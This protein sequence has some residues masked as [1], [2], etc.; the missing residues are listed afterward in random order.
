MF[1]D[2]L[3]ID[4]SR[5]FSGVFK[6]EETRS[7]KATHFLLVPR[8]INLLQLAVDMV[9]TRLFTRITIVLTN[10]LFTGYIAKNGGVIGKGNYA[11]MLTLNN[12]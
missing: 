7:L 4:K 10:N 1:A 9:V 2:A 12:Y 6:W 3:T 8:S 5:H 11:I